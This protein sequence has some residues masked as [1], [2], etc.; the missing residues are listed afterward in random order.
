MIDFFFIVG[1]C[2]ASNSLLSNIWVVDFFLVFGD[3][4]GVLGSHVIGFRV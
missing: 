2:H 1:N 4:D 3:C